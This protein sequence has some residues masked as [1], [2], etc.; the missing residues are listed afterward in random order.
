ENARRSE[1]SLERVAQLE[2]LAG[3]LSVIATAL[4]S[5]DV[6]DTAL[7][8]FKRVIAYDRAVFWRRD[9]GGAGRDGHWRALGSRGYPQGDEPEHNPAPLE[10]GQAALFAE[11]ASNHRILFL[12]DASLDSRF[13]SEAAPATGAWLGVPLVSK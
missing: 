12:A 4:Y 7:D 11:M 9:D 10:G 5:E 3:A 6:T 2:A 8:Q 1:E 13:Q